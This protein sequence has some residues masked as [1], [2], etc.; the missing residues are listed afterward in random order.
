MCWRISKIFSIRGS[1]GAG[2][3]FAALRRGHVDAG[4][5][6]RQVRRAEFEAGLPCFVID[7][8]RGIELLKGAGLEPLV[9]DDQTIS[10][11]EEDLDAIAA[12]IEKQKQVAREGIL[13]EKFLHHTEKTVEALAHVCRFCAEENT[14]CGGELREHQLAPWREPSSCPAAVIAA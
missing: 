9:P 4:E 11:P 1:T 6:Q 12:A 14:D 8:G 10:L 2:V 5:K 13:A 7:A 3:A